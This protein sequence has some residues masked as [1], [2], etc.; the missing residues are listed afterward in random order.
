MRHT[1]TRTRSTVNICIDYIHLI[2]KYSN[3]R[4]THNSQLIAQ[5]NFICNAA[6][7]NVREPLR[8]APLNMYIFYNRI[9]QCPTDRRPMV[10]ALLPGRLR[11]RLPSVKQL[12]RCCRRRLKHIQTLCCAA[13]LHCKTTHYR[14]AAFIPFDSTHQTIAGVVCANALCCATCN[15]HFILEI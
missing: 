15:E 5:T 13:P 9:S 4:L 3:G 14:V 11:R 1:H 7:R 2:I 12:M 6:D 8:C 10:P